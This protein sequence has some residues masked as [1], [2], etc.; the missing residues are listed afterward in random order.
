[1]IEYRDSRGAVSRRRITV[2]NIQ[3]GSGGV[4]CLWARCHERQAD[5]SFRADR[6]QAIITVDGE[7]L[8]DVGSFLADRLGVFLEADATER[9]RRWPQ[10]LATVRPQAQIP[11]G[12][13]LADGAK[14][15]AEIET[16]TNFCA[17]LA[18]MA[19]FG[20][21]RDEEVAL[22]RYLANMRP[23]RATMLKAVDCMMEAGPAAQAALLNAAAA[24]M[25]ADGVDH[26]EEVRFLRALRQDL[27]GLM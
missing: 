8:T 24:V 13:S 3:P 11:A 17:R 10:V 15:P 19:G 26:P 2:W 23:S 4:P 27:I 9:A 6:I 16:A 20:L 25:A 14:H 1:M 22:A 7:I 21:D 5:R 18:A 12:L